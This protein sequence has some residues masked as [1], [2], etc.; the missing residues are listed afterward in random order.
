MKRL[1][2]HVRAAAEKVAGNE[3][4][5]KV[6]MAVLLVYLGW[7]A[8]AYQLGQGGGLW[9]NLAMGVVALVA[10]A[11][12]PWRFALTI[13]T[14][15][16]VGEG[17]LRKWVFPDRQPAV[18]ALKYLLLAAVYLRFMVEWGTG[19][20]KMIVPSRLSLLLLLYVGWVLVQAF[21]PALPDAWIGGVGVFQRLFMMPLFLVVPQVCRDEKDWIRYFQ[22]QVIVAAAPLVLGVVQFFH[23]PW[24]LINLDPYGGEG[25]GSAFGHFF[26]LMITRPTGSFP[27]ISQFNAYITLVAAMALILLTAR[28]HEVRFLRWLPYPTILLV[29]FGVLASQSRGAA[30]MFA[31][32]LALIF[33]SRRNLRLPRRGPVLWAGAMVLLGLGAAV[34]NKEIRNHA[35]GRFTGTEAGQANESREFF[36]RMGII[37]SGPLKAVE[38]LRGGFLGVGAGFRTNLAGRIGARYATSSVRSALGAEQGVGDEIVTEL[39]V[40]GLVLYYLLKVT[41]L[42]LIL[43]EARSHPSTGWRRLLIFPLFVHLIDLGL[44]LEQRDPVFAFYYWSGTGILLAA[45]A[46]RAENESAASLE[47]AES[48]RSELDL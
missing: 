14:L 25:I 33:G 36:T 23:E 34:M 40:P 21:N 8:G 2:L 18:Y 24:D 27:S 32:I 22:F 5:L 48:G 46:K 19:K 38:D 15:V 26:G 39:G 11:A 43:R 7:R 10:L 41:F 30:V 16:V 6:G 35:F 47:A 12:L 29:L 42:L 1:G 3:R 9:A 13:A 20:V 17:A 37:A 4:L 28:E 44:G 31:V 45:M